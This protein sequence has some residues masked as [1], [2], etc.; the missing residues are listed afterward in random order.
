MPG[1]L[2]PPPWVSDPDMHHGMCWTH[3]P[4]CLPGS[5]TG[6]FLW[7]RRRGKGSRLS[8]RKR[9]PQFYVSGKMPIKGFKLYLAAS[10]ETL[11][12]HMFPNFIPWVFVV[13]I[14]H[15]WYWIAMYCICLVTCHMIHELCISWGTFRIIILWNTQVNPEV[16]Y[17]V[18][19]CRYT[20]MLVN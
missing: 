17:R 1:T 13:L 10:R 3:V 20:H 12:V 8:R 2:S 11:R 4:W 18:T 9:S 15:W 5:L 14:R 19:I 7:N 16:S 6:G